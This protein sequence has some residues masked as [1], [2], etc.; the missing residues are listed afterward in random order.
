MYCYGEKI[1]LKCFYNLCR[2]YACLLIRNDKGITMKNYDV[3]LFDF[4]GTFADT[5]E[6]LFESVQSAVRALGFEPLD[7][8]TLRRFIGPPVYESFKRELPINDEQADFAVTKYREA[9]AKEG[10]TK[11][12]IYDGNLELLKEL[13]ESGIKAAVASAKPQ[14][15]LI[16]IVANLGLEDYFE[17]ISAPADDKADPSKVKLIEKAAEALKADKSRVL[18]VGDRYFDIAGANGAGVDSVGVTFGYGSEAELRDAGAT[19]IAHSV[20]EVRKVIFR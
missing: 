5:G 8:A 14:K 13:K 7:N 6:G 4:D 3:V 16:K 11:L 20:A 1:V 18:M 2:I 19:F 12:K 9:Y 10:I 15:F 17:Y